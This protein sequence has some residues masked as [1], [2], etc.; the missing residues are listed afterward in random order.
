MKITQVSPQKNNPRRMSVYVDDNYAFSL[1]DVDAVVMG[2]KP[3]KEITQEEIKNCLFESQFGKAKA[4]ATELLSHKALSRKMLCDELKKREYDE[5]VICEV[6][7]EFQN[8]GYIDD[9]NFSMLFLEHAYS[10]VW[11]EKKV[12]Y[13]LYL[14]G[15]DANIVEDAL[16]CFELPGAKEI[17]DCIIQ[18]YRD[19]DFTDFK[20]K[21]KIMRHFASR[22]FDFSV[23]E[24]ALKRIDASYE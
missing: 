14:K 6:I 16:A 7:N 21:Q 18:K 22:G 11:G 20:V 24:E 1:D 15:V 9:M 13:E 2:I 3:G 12:R 17:A 5:L 19:E 23:V 4:K 8:L 10:K